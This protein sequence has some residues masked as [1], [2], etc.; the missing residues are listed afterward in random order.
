MQNR[1]K[2]KSGKYKIYAG[3]YRTPSLT[4]TENELI[5]GYQIQ[6]KNRVSEQF[7]KVVGLYQSS[8]TNYQPTNYP[9]I[10]NASYVTADGQVLEKQL[11]LT[12]TDNST[13]CQQIAKIYLEK[14]RQQY[15]MAILLSILYQI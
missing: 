11:N 9:E 4:I 3:E 15:Q 10:T 6:T 12:F 14:S 13:R 2:I 5:S 1:L 8:E 7:N